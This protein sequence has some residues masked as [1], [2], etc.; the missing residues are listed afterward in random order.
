MKKALSYM[1]IG[2]LTSSAVMLFFQNKEDITRSFNRAM[3][4]NKRLVNKFKAI[5]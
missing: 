1:M 3:K 5:F 4:E 2:A